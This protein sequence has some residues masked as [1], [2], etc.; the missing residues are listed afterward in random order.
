MLELL[1]HGVAAPLSSWRR[2]AKA[3]VPTRLKSNPAVSNSERR[4]NNNPARQTNGI[5]EKRFKFRFRRNPDA[6]CVNVRAH[7]GK[8]WGAKPTSMFREQFHLFERFSFT[9]K[10]MSFVNLIFGEI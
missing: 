8:D 7:S 9:K 3:E 1:V 4:S 5:V 10:K 6:V 2:G